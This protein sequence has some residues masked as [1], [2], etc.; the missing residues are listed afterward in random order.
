MISPEI[1]VVEMET[2]TLCNRQCSYCPNSFV[3]RGKHYLPLEAVKKIVGELS[4]L[5]F[6]GRFSFHFYNEPLL[7]QRLIQIIAIVKKALP[8][9]LLLLYTNGDYLTLPLFEKLVFSGINKFLITRQEQS[10]KIHNLDWIEKLSDQ[11]KSYLIYKTYQDPNILYT[12]RGGLLPEIANPERP[13][14][15]PCCLPSSHLV[16]SALGNVL[17]CFEDYRE[18]EIMGNIFS[19]T[20][21]EIWTSDA[22]KNRRRQLSLGQRSCTQICR[23][24]NNTE[25]QNLHVDTSEY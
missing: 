2:C 20:I 9:A 17:L 25:N 8:K 16:I 19:N 13:L 21:R 18:Q 14:G 11:E 10:M 23:K 1:Q 5:R 24:C 7:D 6:Q 12:N 3:N 15:I 22:F 4:E